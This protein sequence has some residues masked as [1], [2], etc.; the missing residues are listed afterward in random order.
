MPL[1]PRPSELTIDQL[2]SLWLAHKDPDLR[3]AIEEVAYRRLEAQHKEK[4]L[5]EVESLYAIIHQAWKEEVGD[6]LIALECLKAL[7]GENRQTRGDLP[8]IPSAPPR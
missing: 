8:Q 1:N 6:T 2:R 4:V 3:R 7:L 5:R